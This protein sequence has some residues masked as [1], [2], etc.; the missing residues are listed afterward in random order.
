[1][2]LL[3]GKLAFVT[4]KRFWYISLFVY[5]LKSNFKKLILRVPE[6]TS[7][8]VFEFSKNFGFHVLGKAVVSVY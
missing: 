5:F 8:Q 2:L 4:I 7:L 6:Y 3:F 1:M